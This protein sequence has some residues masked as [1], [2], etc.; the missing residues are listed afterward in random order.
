MSIYAARAL[1]K[2]VSVETWAIGL[3]K[4]DDTLRRQTNDFLKEFRAAGGFDGLA[5]KYM[6]FRSCISDIVS[7]LPF[8]GWKGAL[9]KSL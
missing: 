7:S 9:W 5:N 8:R 1:L 3:R 4:G 6:S 2:P